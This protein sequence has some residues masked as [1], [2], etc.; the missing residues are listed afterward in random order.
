[1]LIDTKYCQAS[2]N[3]ELLE[4]I[5]KHLFEEGKEDFIIEGDIFI[6]NDLENFQ[7]CDRVK[8]KLE[9]KGQKILDRLYRGNYITYDELKQSCLESPYN[10]RYNLC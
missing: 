9:K 2:S 1:M 6:D 10:L 7:L 8:N 5:A 3:K 4:K